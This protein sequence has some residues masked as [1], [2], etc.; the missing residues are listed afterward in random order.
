LRRQYAGLPRNA[1]LRLGGRGRYRVGGD[2]ETKQPEGN[3]DRQSFHAHQRLLEEPYPTECT[4]RKLLFPI[5]WRRGS[6]PGR[7]A[8]L[9]PARRTRSTL[10]PARASASP[11]NREPTD[12]LY[13]GDDALILPPPIRAAMPQGGSDRAGTAPIGLVRRQHPVLSNGHADGRDKPG[14]DAENQ[15]NQLADHR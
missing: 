7:R 5:S 10:P 15:R 13:G 6:D 11:V 1:G 12:E 9:R 14:H 2:G 4:K 8:G 3:G